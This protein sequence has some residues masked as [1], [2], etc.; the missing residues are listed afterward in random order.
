MQDEESL[1]RRAHAAYR[2]AGGLDQPSSESGIESTGGK[3]YV[4]LRNIQ[5]V[6]AVYSVEPDGS[7]KGQKEVPDGILD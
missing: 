4:V 6:M 2:R 1:V 3:D 7:L 5:G